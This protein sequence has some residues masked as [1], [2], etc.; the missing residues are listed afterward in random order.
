MAATQMTITLT[1]ENLDQARAV[2]AAL[3]LYIDMERE[4][5]S[6]PSAKVDGGW[7]KDD[8]DRF[9][10]ARAVLMAMTGRATKGLRK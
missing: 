6:D 10:G 1:L 7:T 8:E 3:E 4:R 9:N 2:E 5:G